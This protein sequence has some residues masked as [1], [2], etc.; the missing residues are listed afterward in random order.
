MDKKNGMKSI[1]EIVLNCKNWNDSKIDVIIILI[2][3][4]LGTGYNGRIGRVMFAIC[5]KNCGIESGI[6]AEQC[7]VSFV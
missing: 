6:F 4:P 2:E 7:E 1:E 3:V 5:K